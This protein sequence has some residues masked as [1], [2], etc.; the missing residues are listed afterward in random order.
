MPGQV[1]AVPA[2]LGEKSPQGEY[3]VPF[4]MDHVGWSGLILLTGDAPFEPAIV[5]PAVDARGQDWQG[6]F[7]AT[8]SERDW[9]A[10]MLWIRS[11]DKVPN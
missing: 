7:V 9:K 6:N 10:E 2:D 3:T 1:E 8:A 11:V 4:N 5:E